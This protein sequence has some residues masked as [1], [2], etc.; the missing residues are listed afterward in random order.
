[1]RTA[2]YTAGI[3]ICLAVIATAAPGASD[4]QVRS[5]PTS[6]GIEAA[7]PIS[8]GVNPNINILE[9]RG[10]GD[11]KHDGKKAA[12][13]KSCKKIG[14]RLD[15]TDTQCDAAGCGPCQGKA[16][17]ASAERAYQQE[18]AEAEARGE[19]APLRPLSTNGVCSAPGTKPKYTK[20][21]QK[22]ADDW[23]DSFLQEYGGE[24][25]AY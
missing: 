18:V 1:M 4:Y 9:A 21:D 2:I 11:K 25:A 24:T 14:C 3:T 12:S 13:A 16:L 7:E 5:E 6:T 8:T 15:G 20:E 19:P 17:S 10:K 23:A 22:G